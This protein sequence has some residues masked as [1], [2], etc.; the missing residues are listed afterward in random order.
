MSSWGADQP[1]LPLKP[2]L[3]DRV[4]LADMGLIPEA[5]I[6]ADQT[7]SDA[8]DAWRAHP[9]C[10]KHRQHVAAQVFGRLALESV[11]AAQQSQKSA[12]AEL[13]N[14]IIN[15]IA[16]GPARDIEKRAQSIMVRA[17]EQRL[18]VTGLGTGP[19][20]EE[21]R[22][23]LTTLE[24]WIEADPQPRIHYLGARIM[25][26]LRPASPRNQPAQQRPAQT[27]AAPQT[28]RPAWADPKLNMALLGRTILL[29]MGLI[30]DDDPTVSDN[31]SIFGN[32]PKAAQIRN[33]IAEQVLGKFILEVIA[34]AQSTQALQQ[35]HL[36]DLGNDILNWLSAQDHEDI[37]AVALERA[38]RLAKR[39]MGILPLGSSNDEAN[40]AYLY[41]ILYLW[42][43]Q[44]PD[45]R[46]T[47]LIDRI[48]AVLGLPRIP[49]PATPQPAAASSSMSSGGA[50]L[51]IPAPR[52][53]P[54]KPKNAPPAPDP[55]RGI[56]PVLQIPIDD[57]A[58]SP[59]A[60]APVPHATPVPAPAPSHKPQPA[61]DRPPLW[62]P[63][64]STNQPDIEPAP[65]P[66]AQPV[67][68]PTQTPVPVAPPS[69]PQPP[70]LDPNFRRLP[71]Y[72]V[73][74]CSGSMAGDPIES[75]RAGVRSLTSD[76]RS[77]PQALETAWLSVISFGSSAHQISPLTDLINFQEPT[78]DAQGI[79]SLGEALTLLNNCIV[80]EV[81]PPDSAHKGD[82]T[83][84]IFLMTDGLPTDAWEQPAKILIQNH[85][86]NIIACAAGS[87]ADPE[88]LKQ[89]GHHVIELHTL[90]PDALKSFFK[91]A[92]TAVKSVAS[93]P[94]PSLPDPASNLPPPPPNINIVP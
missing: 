14:E 35:Q 11:V 16:L 64:D 78:L 89:I 17:A 33:Q 5:D 79:T 73:L 86:A 36:A 42:I 23:F 72:L 49:S 88:L 83:P 84:L 40:D 12:L 8:L 60:S 18:R 21:N 94:N 45:A 54:K 32:M 77:D 44:S 58:D 6:L 70:P 75:M 46:T 63:E 82:W 28:P 38:V 20:E 85:H 93:S 10:R 31:L 43:S 4:V 29:D 74:D 7:L 48:H 57:P 62:N 66:P 26:A 9:N 1:S 25:A 53:A 37:P 41:T 90:Q 76:L 68:T 80:R 51:N 22:Y 69:S 92:S 39:R 81:R 50:A 15:Y 55:T 71:V 30:P 65:Q 13:G 67:Y 34:L 59:I 3:T 91:W 52:P 61:P 24:Q 47:R 27:P 56:P 2:G 19:D 87:N